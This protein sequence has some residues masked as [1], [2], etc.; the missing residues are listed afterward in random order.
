ML[1]IDK[2]LMGAEARIFDTLRLN[3][4][5][6]HREA[7]KVAHQL[8]LSPAVE[9]D[10]YTWL[11]HDLS[12]CSDRLYRMRENVS[13]SAISDVEGVFDQDK[14]FDL[15]DDPDA[16]RFMPALEMPL[17]EFDAT[18]YRT[19]RDIVYAGYLKPIPLIGVLAVYRQT[20]GFYNLC[21]GAPALRLVIGPAPV[22]KPGSGDYTAS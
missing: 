11:L 9:P 20:N 15:F 5:L 6:F 1:S 10:A 21:P 18:D 3:E 8:A 2:Y 7:N 22:A 13:L 14:L 19:L 17:R 12:L 16:E 4:C